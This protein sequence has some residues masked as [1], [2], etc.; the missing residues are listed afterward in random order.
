M[1]KAVK[2]IVCLVLALV[3]IVMGY[4]AYVLIDY[5]RIG[6]EVIDRNPAIAEKAEVNKEYDMVSWNIGFGAYESD[7]GF[8]MDGGTESR[9]WSK[10]RLKSNMEKIGSLLDEQEVQFLLLQEVDI[11]ATRSYHMDEF[12]ML[13]E[14]LEGQNYDDL[15]VCNY[16]SPYLMYPLTRPHGKSVSGIVAFSQFGIR[17]AERV[18]LPV[19][20]SLMKLVDLDRCYA[21]SY[22]PVSDGRELVLFNVHLSAYTSDG[23]IATEQLQMLLQDMQGEYEAGNYAVCGG[24]FN[25]DILGD[26]GVYFGRAETAYNWAQPLPEGIFEGTNLTLIAPLNEAQPV[27]SCRN[28]DGPYHAGQFVLTVDGFIV[29][30]NVSVSMTE[31]IDTGFAYSDHNPVHMSFKLAE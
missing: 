20:D 1:K 6:N 16:D 31:V 24:D 22:I 7:Y 13:K 29:S 14:G 10:E 25:K 15:F 5:H 12:A 11:D 30:D 21:K 9:A 26:S 8:F 17:S 2:V 4:L 27:P 23:A 28:A 18:E 19:E 3:L